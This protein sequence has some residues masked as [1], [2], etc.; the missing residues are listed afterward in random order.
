[1]N[2]N[3]KNNFRN[4]Q[5]NNQPVLT[6]FPEIIKDFSGNEYDVWEWKGTFRKG[7][8]AVLNVETNTAYDY[9]EFRKEIEILY[10]QLEPM[11]IESYEETYQL[12]GVEA[13]EEMALDPRG[14]FVG[15]MV[16]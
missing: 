14:V 7:M 16:P 6:R 5:A 15:F 3:Q 2:K 8:T 12:K 4:K 10:K 9:K 1:M 13:V 11:D